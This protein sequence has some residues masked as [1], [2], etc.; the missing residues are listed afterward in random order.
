MFTLIYNPY[1]LG[2]D[3]TAAKGIAALITEF[4]LRKQPL[5]F[6]NVRKDVIYVFTGVMQD[7]FK[8]FNSK[9]D[10]DKF[11]DGKLKFDLII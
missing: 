2:A 5:Y 10:L 6:T 3:F 7:D 1:Y 4:S 9:E 11:I 8:Y